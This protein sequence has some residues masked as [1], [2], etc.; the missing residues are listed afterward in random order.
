MRWLD[1][2]TYSLDMSLRKPQE[3]VMDREAW[4]AAVLGVTKSWT[5]LGDWT[6]LNPLWLS[7]E[8]ICLPFKRPGFLSCVWKIP[9][10]N[11]LLFSCLGNPMGRGT[12]Q[13]TVM[14]LQELD[15]TYQVNHHCTTILAVSLSYLALLYWGIFISYSV[16]WRFLSLS[17]A[18]RFNTG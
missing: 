2:I 18:D 9:N 13:A 11:L 7:Q 10:G 4:C 17:F 12:W 3:L 14:T 8:R 6:E 15:M 16:F 5:R 1:G